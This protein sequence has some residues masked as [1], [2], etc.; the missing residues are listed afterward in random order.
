MKLPDSHSNAAQYAGKTSILPRFAPAR[1]NAI[2][3]VEEMGDE[4]F[5][6][7]M[8]PPSEVRAIQRQRGEEPCFCTD[9]RYSCTEQCDLR[10]ECFKVRAVWLR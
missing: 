8:P 10:K 4:G 5:R 2:H 6:R 9:K 7:R 3:H 1:E